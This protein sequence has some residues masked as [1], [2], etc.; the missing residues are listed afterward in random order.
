MDI[1][2]IFILCVFNFFKNFGFLI[3]EVFDSLGVSRFFFFKKTIVNRTASKI[4]FLSRLIIDIE[5]LI[6][7]CWF[8][9][10][11]TLLNSFISSNRLW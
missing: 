9:H 8:L 5:K 1:E 4:T 3:V 2:G 11:A 6:F 10:H 7:L